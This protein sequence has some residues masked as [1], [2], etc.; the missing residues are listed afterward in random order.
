MTAIAKSEKALWLRFLQFPLVRILV[1]GGGLIYLMGRTEGL[2]SQVK[3]N[4]ALGVVIALGMGLVAFAIYTA[5]GRFIER[6]EVTEL[7]LPGAPREWAIGALIGVGLYTGCVLALMILGIY[8]IEGLNP[9]S[10]MIPAIALALKSG[11]FEELIFRGVLFRSV[12]D[13]AGS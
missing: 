1:L 7:S 13:M 11:I 10:Y 3:D 8:R 2:V 6:R 9:V 12:E 4:P 5:W